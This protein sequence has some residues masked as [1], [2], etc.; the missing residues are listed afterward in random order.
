MIKSFYFFKKK[1]GFLLTMPRG[2]V[3]RER[4]FLDFQHKKVNIGRVVIELFN[5]IVPITTK[6]FRSLCTGE[7]GLAQSTNIPL[8][9][10]GSVIHRI[11][12]GFV[13]Q[14]GDFTLGN[15]K[16]GEAIYPGGRFD[17]EKLD[18]LNHERPMLVSMANSGPD[19]NGSQFF[20]TLARTPHLDGKHQVFGRVIK[21]SEVVYGFQTLELSGE[22]PVDDLFIVNCGQMMKKVDLKKK[23]A[24]EKALNKG[25]DSEDSD[26]DS[27][28]DSDDSDKKSRKKSKKRRKKEKKEKKKRKKK[29]RKA[30]K[31]KWDQENGEGENQDDDQNQEENHFCS[32][33][34]EDLP[35]EPKIFYLDRDYSR[36]DRE[37]AEANG[38]TYIPEKKLTNAEL[39]AQQADIAKSKAINAS[40][41][42]SGSKILDEQ[43]KN[44]KLNMFG[45]EETQK[46]KLE[47]DA[48]KAKSIL[49]QKELSEAEKLSKEKM[50][51]PFSGSKSEGMFRFDIEAEFGGAGY[52]QPKKYINAREKKYL[53]QKEQARKERQEEIASRDKYEEF[54]AYSGKSRDYY[55]R[56]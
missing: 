4:V 43:K 9:F 33:D 3:E 24:M 5:D 44:E 39:R 30:E 7:A 53:E 31:K 38:Q 51:N 15:G 17:D 25:S 32:I 29:E 35:E 50:K 14:G 8:C 18:I 2:K 40:I 28:S 45:A 11:I 56:M 41:S 19:T 6:N 16:G 1:S 34:P 42:I 21:G 46:N 26:S 54:G 37:R 48:N 47:N 23:R 12:P 27:G 10:R 22:R 49:K 13:V 55:P 52:K 36:L 20:I